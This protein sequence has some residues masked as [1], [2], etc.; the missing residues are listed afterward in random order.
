MAA[1][2][3]AAGGRQCRAGGCGR[4]RRPPRARRTPRASACRTTR[5]TGPA[6]AAAGARPAGPAPARL[7]QARDDRSPPSTGRAR[8]AAGAR[9]A[10]P[11]PRPRFERLHRRACAAAGGRPAPDKG[12]RHSC[13]H[14]V[15]SHTTGM[16]LPPHASARHERAQKK[17]RGEGTTLPPTSKPTS[18]KLA[19][20]CAM[21]A[22][23]AS[24]APAAPAAD[25]APPGGA[26]PATSARRNAARLRQLSAAHMRSSVISTGRS[27]APHCSKV[28]QRALFVGKRALLSL[29][30]LSPRTGCYDTAG[31]C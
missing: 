23:T 13:L 28:M 25:G 5:G 10:A 4:P 16:R 6:H 29:S 20:S 8:A 18:G 7:R 9:P 21:T 3:P 2:A 31:Q 15:S 14:A 11:R 22:A 27:P 12:D 24:S 17:P 26:P 19:E 30:G 1:G